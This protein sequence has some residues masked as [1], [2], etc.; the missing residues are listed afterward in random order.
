[1]EWRHAVPFASFIRSFAHSFAFESCRYD[2]LFLV[3]V[4]VDLIE[5]IILG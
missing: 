1:M 2:L 4:V 3:V 5:G